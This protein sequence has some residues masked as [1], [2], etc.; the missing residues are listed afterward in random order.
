MI[1]M[2]L[3]SAGKAMINRWK[4]DRR[5]LDFGAC[6]S[7]RRPKKQR[8]RVLDWENWKKPE[9]LEL[10]GVGGG[11]TEKKE[12]KRFDTE[13]EEEEEE[14]DDDEEKINYIQKSNHSIPN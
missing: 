1:E 13:E 2:H 11:E 4:K 5:T 7:W 3:A 12:K 8:H 10:V 6:G 9:L 14:D